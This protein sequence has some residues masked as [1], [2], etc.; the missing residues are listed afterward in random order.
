MVEN[1]QALPN[2]IVLQKGVRVSHYNKA[3]Y[4]QRKNATSTLLVVLVPQQTGLYQKQH[5]SC[6]VSLVLLT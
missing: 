4:W 6:I 2:D 1:H 5:V 3:L